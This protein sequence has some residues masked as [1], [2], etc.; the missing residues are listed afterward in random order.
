MTIQFHRKRRM[1]MV[2]LIVSG[3]AGRM[4]TRIITLAND[5]KEIEPSQTVLLRE[6]QTY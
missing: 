5:H 2:N 4:G 1:T 3:A 6:V